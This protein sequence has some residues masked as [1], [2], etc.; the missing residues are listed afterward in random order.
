MKQ[1]NHSHLNKPIFDYS[2]NKKGVLL[3]VWRDNPNDVWFYRV[4]LE[5]NKIYDLFYSECLLVNNV[6][7]KETS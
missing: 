5:N 4:R 1:E 7:E 6:T 2:H 3:E